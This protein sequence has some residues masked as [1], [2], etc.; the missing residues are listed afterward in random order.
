MPATHGFL[1]ILNDARKEV[2]RFL[3]RDG[4]NVVGIE[5]PE[6][7][8]FPDIDLEPYDPQRVISRRHAVI[9]REGDRYTIEH[10]GKNPTLLNGEPIPPTQ[11]VPLRPD[12][13]LLFGRQVPARFALELFPPPDMKEVA[14]ELGEQP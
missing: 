8:L 11:P 4:E 9:R 10:T 7:E 3:I 13:H 12:D 5:I 6:K 2:G 1:L 14:E